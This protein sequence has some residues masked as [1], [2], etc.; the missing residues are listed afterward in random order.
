MHSAIICLLLA[1]LTISNGMK[2]PSVTRDVELDIPLTEKMYKRSLDNLP[3]ITS[4]DLSEINQQVNSRVEREVPSLISEK[5]RSD[6]DIASEE[7]SLFLRNLFRT[8]G[9]VVQI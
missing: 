4:R 9:R 6:E 2:L 5:I 8:K 3:E 7:N 1:I